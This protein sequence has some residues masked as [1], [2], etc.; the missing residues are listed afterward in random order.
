[1]D[2]QNRKLTQSATWTNTSVLEFAGERNP[3]QVVTEKA[4]SLILRAC[5]AGIPGPPI[6]P[7]DLAKFLNIRIVPNNSILDARTIPFGGDR[8]VIEF[9]PDRPQSR[10]RYSIAHE[11]THTF[12]NDCAREVR[13]RLR[14]REIRGDEWQ[15]ETVCNIGAAEI[16]MPIG[17][18]RALENESPSIDQLLRV[19]ADHAVST[20][21]L[22]L[23]FVKLTTHKCIVFCA[24]RKED[25][26]NKYRIDYAVSSD[27]W[28]GVNLRGLNLPAGSPVEE[29]TAIGYTAKGAIHA[30][31]DVGSVRVECVGLPP[32]PNR[33]YPRVLGIILPN[34]LGQTTHRK[35][36]YLK[37]DATK[38]RGNG[39][40]IIAHVVNDGASTW[41]GGF[42]RVVGKKWPKVQSAFRLWAL[43]NRSN[44]S[45]GN[46]SFIDVD[47][48][49]TICNMIAQRGYGPSPTPRIR[50][51]AL[52]SCLE[53]LA[54][55]A[56]E[57]GDSVHMPRIGCGQAG[58]SWDIVSELMEEKLLKRSIDVTVYDLTPGVI[59]EKR[60]PT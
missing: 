55:R 33:R 35:I 16:L 9:N 38:P 45:L 32:Y 14:H 13:N 54:R 42:A 52:D 43:D 39:P 23:R 53:Q 34:K 10:T 7:F 37:G 22:L 58:G 31:G 12:F 25:D 49:L 28:T 6:D 57:H 59:F 56:L 36:T 8:F 18:F 3:I 27:S 41:G 11:I 48:N 21:A 17:S 19:R 47:A 29:C 1:M 20:E 46:T 2:L 5:E 44:L 40:R 60:L 51:D 26:Q 50:Y 15:L 30:L 24:S 4:R